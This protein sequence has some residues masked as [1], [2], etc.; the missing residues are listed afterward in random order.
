MVFGQFSLS[1]FFSSMARISSLLFL[2]FFP[3]RSVS[4]NSLSLFKI[5]IKDAENTSAATG[6]FSD[7]MINNALYFG[8][9]AFIHSLCARPSF[10]KILNVPQ[11]RS[12]YFNYFETTCISG[13]R[14]T[15]LLP[16]IRFLS[17]PSF[18]KLAINAG[19]NF[20]SSRISEDFHDRR[21]RDRSSLAC[22]VHF[23]DRPF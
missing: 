22:D 5:L 16:A 18:E 10:K 13:A 9:W 8:L 4:R 1:P 14:K 2:K 12:F 11:A 19:R 23:C 20:R 7:K 15:V 3:M 17:P 6:T 21:K